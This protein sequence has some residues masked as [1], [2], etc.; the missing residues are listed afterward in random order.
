[1]DWVNNRGLGQKLQAELL[2]HGIRLAA[3]A[4]TKQ[5]DIP[6]YTYLP[7]TVEAYQDPVDLQ[8]SK[9]E[10]NVRAKRYVKRKR[11]I[12]SIESLQVDG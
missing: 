1:M 9:Q 8:N 10:Q 5:N 11:S 12:S 6:T 2:K 3:D 4:E 7:R